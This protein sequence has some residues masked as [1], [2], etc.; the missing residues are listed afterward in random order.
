MNGIIASRRLNEK[1][2]PA[3]FDE[4]CQLHVMTLTK[5]AIGEDV[6]SYINQ[7]EFRALVENTEATMEEETKFNIKSLKDVI[8]IIC[9]YDPRLLESS[10]K[11][12]Y[13]GNLYD[14]MTTADVYG[15][16]RFVRMKCVSFV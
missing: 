3:R 9:W 8:L 7:Y 5:N 14:I 13:R 10:N 2:N 1:I 11:I 4:V 16:K 6:R 12:M 15:R